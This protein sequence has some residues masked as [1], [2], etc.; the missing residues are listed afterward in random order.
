MATV[1]SAGEWMEAVV[2]LP[3]IKGGNLL[4]CPFRFDMHAY[5]LSL[6]ATT[7]LRLVTI[8][9]VL[10]WVKLGTWGQTTGKRRRIILCHKCRIYLVESCVSVPYVPLGRSMDISRFT[11]RNCDF[12]GLATVLATV[13]RQAEI[14]SH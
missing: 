14:A 9:P 2:M 13:C 3:F 6:L 1:A 8:N 4:R 10:W 5:S 12:F 11:A 7:W